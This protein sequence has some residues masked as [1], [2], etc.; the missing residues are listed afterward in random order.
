MA[1]LAV[2]LLT[3][4]L[5]DRTTG[6][7]LKDVH[8]SIAGATSSTDS[9]GRYRLIVPHPGTFTL[10]LQSADVPVERI[11]VTLTA[12]SRAHLDRV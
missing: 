10:T 9:R 5:S 3:G 4:Q 7:P 11:R 8:V 12:G 6:Q 2:T 1:A